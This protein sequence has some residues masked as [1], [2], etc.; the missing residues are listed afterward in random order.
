M[1]AIALNITYVAF[2]V[3]CLLCLWRLYLGPDMTDR[4]LALDTLYIN[5]MGL[6]MLVG[7]S[8]YLQG[9]ESRSYFYELAVLIALMGFVGTVA[10]ARFLARGDAIE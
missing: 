5:A 10:G 9:S 3:A 4:L 1:L 6:A 2:S 7:I 8:G